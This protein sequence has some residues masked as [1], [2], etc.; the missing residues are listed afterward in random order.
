MSS[1]LELR[2]YLENIPLQS[3]NTVVQHYIKR[4]QKKLTLRA[5]LFRDRN[6]LIIAC[7]EHGD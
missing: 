4:R 2:A 6:K 7:M 3:G 1:I 5:V